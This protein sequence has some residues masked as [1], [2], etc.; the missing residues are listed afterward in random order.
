MSL[1]P[2]VV[3]LHGRDGVEYLL[4]SP[5]RSLPWI[6]KALRIPPF[7]DRYTAEV[8][9]AKAVKELDEMGPEE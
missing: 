2:F 1:T 4:N 9:A 6:V 3:V 8:V 7:E 5:E